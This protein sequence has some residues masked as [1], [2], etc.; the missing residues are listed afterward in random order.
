MSVN[1]RILLFAVVAIGITAILAGTALYTTR[2]DRQIRER[3]IASQNQLES[4]SRLKA[5]IWPFLNAL[6]RLREQGQDTTALLQERATRV[7]A[8]Q[9]QLSLNLEQEE[10]EIN[11]MGEFKPRAREDEEFNQIIQALLRW[12]ERTEEKVRQDSG[13]KPLPPEEEWGFY[14]DYEK[15]VGQRMTS[16][17]A[18]EREEL[19]WMQRR[20]DLNMARLVLLTKVVALGS[21]VLNIALALFILLPLRSSLRTLRT[22]AEGVGR[23]DFEVALPARGNDELGLLAQAMNR[24][25]S[26]LRGTLQEKQRLLEAEAEASEREARRYSAMLE[27]TVRART[28]E[29][30]TANHQLEESLQQLRLTQSQLLFA[31]RMAAV[32]RLAAGV[33]HEINN[34]LSYILSNLRFIQRELG[35]EEAARLPEREEMLTAVNDARDGAER[36]RDIVQE[37]KTLSRPDELTLGPVDLRTVVQGSLRIASQELRGRARVVEDFQEVPTIQGNGPRLGQVV[38]NLLINAAHAIEPGRAEENEVRVLVRASGSKSV[39][40]V[41]SDT[42]SGIPPENLERIFEP[43]FTTKPVGMGTGLGLSVCRTIIL[44][45][46]GTL[47]VESEVGRGSTFRITLPTGGDQTAP[48][49]PQEPGT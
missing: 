42:G 14:Q 22:T 7:L 6:S 41:V 37:L 36:V 40:V 35:R 1:G 17:E 47:E 12:M 19:E 29:L 49:A 20:W 32:G 11:G 18:A 27:E 21:I 2:M 24:M 28:A 9:T 25:A 46:G 39:I 44:S 48:T 34:P 30:E 16:I 26:E 10:E 15:E 23:G 3:V 38:L 33:G 4:L 13:R 31:D 5:G 8:E 45:L 43:F